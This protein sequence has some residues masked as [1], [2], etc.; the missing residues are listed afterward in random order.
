MFEYRK[1]KGI[2]EGSPTQTLGPA[3]FPFSLSSP[4][5]AAQLSPSPSP[6]R[7]GRP[8]FSLSR[9]PRA[10]PFPFSRC[11][12]G[13]ACRRRFFPSPSCARLPPLPLPLT[14]GPRASAPSS[15]SPSSSPAQRP[16]DISGDLLRLGP[17]RQEA[18]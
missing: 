13:P 2:K 18:A 14:A 1:G 17:A 16:P 9:P 4:S 15:P 11:H 3:Q 5:P 8:T 12:P 6:P 7:V 10:L